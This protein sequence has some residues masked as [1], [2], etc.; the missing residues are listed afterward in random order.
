[1]SHEHSSSDPKYIGPGTW[2]ALHTMASNSKDP[3]V[4][5]EQ[6]RI[7]VDNFKCMDCRKH[8]QEYLQEHPFDMYFTMKDS[9]GR[10]IGPAR[11]MWEFH[12]TVNR[13]LGKPLLDWE[14][15]WNLYSQPDFGICAAGCG[16]ETKEKTLDVMKGATVKSQYRQVEASLQYRKVEIFPPEPKKKSP[17][18]TSSYRI[19]S[20][21]R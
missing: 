17:I 4:F 20:R 1:M 19:T 16:E 18:R 7:I 13:R 12:N 10:L 6:L 15:A 2:S 3:K 21:Q 5:F 8:A 9:K 14:T 11:Y